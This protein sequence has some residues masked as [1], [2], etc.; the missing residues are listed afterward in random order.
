MSTL[1]MALTCPSLGTVTAQG[2][3]P[4][5]LVLKVSNN[6]LRTGDEIEVLVSF[7]DKPAVKAIGITHD[8]ARVGE[9]YKKDGGFILWNSLYTFIG[10]SYGTDS[11]TG[12]PANESSPD[13]LATKRTSVGDISLAYKCIARDPGIYRLTSKIRCVK[14]GTA[15]IVQLESQPVVI[16]VF[17][18]KQYFADIKS[19]KDREL[20]NFRICQLVC[21]SMR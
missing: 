8:C 13:G 19:G 17:P 21:G 10:S 4:D 15:N 11:F 2:L 7:E 1:S 6:S 16:V 9:Y 12:L 3:Y 14:D 18:S 20:N 5:L